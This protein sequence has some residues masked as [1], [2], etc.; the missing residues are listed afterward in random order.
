MSVIHGLF[1][2]PVE[3]GI[4]I[5]LMSGRG[6]GAC[7]NDIHILPTIFSAVLRGHL[8]AGHACLLV[9]TTLL[10]S[11]A[12]KMGNLGRRSRRLERIGYRCE[13][14]LSRHQTERFGGSASQ[15]TA[16]FTGLF[17]TCATTTTINPRSLALALKKL[18]D[19]QLASVLKTVP[20]HTLI[21][22]RPHQHETSHP[23]RTD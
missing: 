3:P 6:K 20:S 8:K 14:R 19:S 7:I 21:E 2:A 11:R 13:Q 16:Y 22:F 23:R 4:D 12:G 15:P 17:N 5:L 18:V 9:L 1:R 10:I